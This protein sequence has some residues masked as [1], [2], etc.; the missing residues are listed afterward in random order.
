MA[1]PRLLRTEAV[2][3]RR[4]DLGE[5]DRILTLF[6]AHHGKL[7]AVAKGIRRP[8]SKLGGHLEL[9]THSQILLARG[10]NLD[11]ITQVDTLDPFIG[12]RENLWRASQAYCAAELIDRLTEDHAENQ[13]LFRLLTSTFERVATCRR[14]DQAV[15]FFEVQALGL[16]GYRPEI[17]RCVKCRGALEP[18]RTWFSVSDGGILCSSCRVSSPACRELSQNAVKVL[19]LYQ[20]GDWET[21]S[22][23]RIGD[24]L[25]A[26]LER[27]LRDYTQYVAETQL[28]SAAFVTSLR[29]QGLIADR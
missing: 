10:R 2:V 1:G 27:V 7:R 28:K 16:L 12:L 13:P 17:T 29:E 8:T 5:T 6:T 9:F 19:R 26:E 22:R 14:P 4:H 25:A 23:L 21:A 18:D 24:D 11:V 20:S 15:R 3:L